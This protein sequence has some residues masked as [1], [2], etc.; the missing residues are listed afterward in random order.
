MQCRHAP[1]RLAS[2]I[3]LLTRTTSQEAAPQL[4]CQPPV[5]IA[6]RPLHAPMVQWEPFQVSILWRSTCLLV[7]IPCT[8]LAPMVGQVLA[9]TAAR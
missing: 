3:S 1:L 6:W 8:T 5:S 2:A 9:A 7:G 4:T